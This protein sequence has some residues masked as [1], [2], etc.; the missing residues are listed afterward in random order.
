M[1]DE[2]KNALLSTGYSF[3]HHAWSSAPQGDYG[4]W[5]EDSQ[6]GSVWGDGKMLNQSI[7]GTIDYFTRDDSAS[8]LT[9]IQSALDNA[10]ISF[11]L[12]TVQFE[13][14]T[15]YIHYE[16]VFEVV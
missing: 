3:A 8:P 13:D 5:A 6:G 1:M 9:V 12:N 4:V 7:Q 14:D 10:G 2:L 11:Y 16:W 15:G